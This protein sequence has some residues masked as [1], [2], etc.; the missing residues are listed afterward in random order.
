MVLLMGEKALEAFYTITDN[1]NDLP[2]I[3]IHPQEARKGKKLQYIILVNQNKHFIIDVSSTPALGNA[4]ASYKGVLTAYRASEVHYALYKEFKI[5]PKR[6]ACSFICEHLISAGRYN[7]FS[8]KEMLERRHMKYIP[9]H[10]DN[11]IEYTHTILF[12]SK[13]CSKI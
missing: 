9:Y 6:W 12:V 7:N 13:T 8:L 1:E 10:F 3:E 2:A 11:I 5:A 4:L